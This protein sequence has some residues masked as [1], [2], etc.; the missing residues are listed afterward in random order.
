M[1]LLEEPRWVV[2]FS[3]AE[4]EILADYILHGMDSLSMDVAVYDILRE[5]GHTLAPEWC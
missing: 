3:L 5:L 2:E 1:E 4:R